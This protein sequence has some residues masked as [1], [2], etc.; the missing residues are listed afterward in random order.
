MQPEEE[1]GNRTSLICSVCFEFSVCLLS[2]C[3]CVL[4]LARCAPYYIMLCVRFYSLPNQ[5]EKSKN[6]TLRFSKEEKYHEWALILISTKRRDRHTER[7]KKMPERK[8]K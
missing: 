2:V 5:I 1:E 8:K 4:A 7:R 6:N 3:V